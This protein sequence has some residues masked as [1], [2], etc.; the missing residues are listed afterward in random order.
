M[1]II[2][3]KVDGVSTLP[4]AE[5]NQIPLE[6]TNM[7]SS[8]GITPSSGDTNQLGKAIANYAAHAAYY[9]DSGT[10]NAKVLSV[11]GSKQGL[12]AYTAGT[13]LGFINLTAN[14]SGSVTVNVNGLGAQNLYNYDG[15]ALMPG[16]LAA[17]KYYRIAYTGS[18]FILLNQSKVTVSLTGATSLTNAYIDSLVLCD[19]SAASWT[20]TLPQLS[21]M[22]SGDEICVVISASAAS[23]ALTV[24]GYG[25]TEYIGSR[26]S[27]RY[28]FA[29]DT[30]T[31]RHA[32]SKW[33]IVSEKQTP[34][35]V[36]AYSADIATA[37]NVQSIVALAN[38][39]AISNQVGLNVVNYRIT[40]L[41]KGFYLAIGTGDF[42]TNYVGN[43]Q[44]LIGKNAGFT[45]YVAVST[46]Y[47][48]SGAVRTLLQVAGL[49]SMDGS[50]D[51]LTLNTIQNSGG[52]LNVRGDLFLVYL[53]DTL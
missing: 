10:A 6:T 28:W 49:F 7:I 22:K 21:T 46:G 32:G 2:P 25:G 23:R 26:L 44:V 35:I 48:P 50:T 33:N 51:Y 27:F 1:Q 43:R 37:D 34:P 24:Q 38:Y 11:G 30:L 14:T 36:W 13:M 41:Q 5:F 19:I 8:A 12:T 39:N 42:A 3:T 15:A 20:L 53:G 18:A 40:P 45:P 52:N 16:S 4:A 31:F 29:N 9:V 17:G 47:A